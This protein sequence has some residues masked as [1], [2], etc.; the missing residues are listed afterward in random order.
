MPA[1]A[2]IIRSPNVAVD[3]HATL[4][5]RPALRITALYGPAIL[6]AQPHSYT[7]LEFVTSGDPA[8]TRRASPGSP[9]EP[10]EHRRDHH[11]LRCLRDAAT[12]FGLTIGPSEAALQ[13]PSL[14]L[15][16]RDLLGR[17]AHG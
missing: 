11:A 3:R 13:R 9:C 15:T 1:T 4:D 12:R 7:P 5:G 6:Y 14:V 10:G 16:A 17:T 8:P 2:T